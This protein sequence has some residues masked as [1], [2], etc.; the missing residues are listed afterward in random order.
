MFPSPDNFDVWERATT[1]LQ[2]ESNSFRPPPY[3]NADAPFNGRQLPAHLVSHTK[4]MR[5]ATDD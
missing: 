3:Y 4:A 1:T 2:N 5:A